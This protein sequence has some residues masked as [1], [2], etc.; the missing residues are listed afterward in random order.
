MVATSVSIDLFQNLHFMF[1][2]HVFLQQFLL[3]IIAHKFSLDQHIMLATSYEA[4]HLGL[5]LGNLCR[6]EIP[7]EWLS[8]QSVPVVGITAT[9]WSADGC[10]ATGF[11]SSSMDSLTRS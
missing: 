8:L 1:L 3:R 6:G 9:S 10:S 11:S 5:V 7:D 4:F 2:G